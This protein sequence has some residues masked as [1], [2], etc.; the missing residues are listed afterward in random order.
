MN[1]RA[2][3]EIVNAFLDY[4]Q[5]RKY[6][7]FDSFPLVS[8]DPTVMFVNATVTPFKRWYS[9]L[10]GPKGNF[11]LVQKCFRLGDTSGLQLIQT[12]PFYF[13]FFR[14]CGSGVFGIKHT[15]AV[16]YLFDLLLVAFGL[17]KRK[18]L[19]VSPDD[20]RF[21][22]ALT[23]NNIDE[24]RIFIIKENGFFWQEWRFGKL[25]LIGNGLTVVYSQF[26]GRTSLQTM[27]RNPNQY[28]DLLNLIYIYGQETESGAVVPVLHPG[29]DLGM[30]LERIASALQKKDGYHID[31]VEPL[32]EVVYGFAANCGVEMEEGIARL[33]TN[34]LRSIFMLA[35]EGVLP[36]NKKHGY[37]LRKLIRHTLELVWSKT[38][39][40][41]PIQDLALSFAKHLG[42]CG[43]PLRSPA[44]L[45]CDILTKEYD[46]LQRA[47]ASAKNLLKHRPNASAEFLRDTYGL[48]PALLSI[49][50]EKGEF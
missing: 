24:E 27:E 18:L 35:D 6:K 49:L 10:A 15:E 4:H 45:T 30:G 11:A 25:G 40:A 8:E 33:L 37:A 21:L 39:T 12:N 23:A 20:D 14:M 22:A 9:D 3:Q 5:K 7:I 31:S 48:P 32:M 47:V 19:F 17:N 38:G 16:G 1:P 13:T 42:E 50:K 46:A 2:T 44:S 36:S 26:E 43:L 34:H 28:I 41:M 29:F